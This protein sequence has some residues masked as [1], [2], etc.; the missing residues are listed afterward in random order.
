M[1]GSVRYE[2]LRDGSR[3]EPLYKREM[4]LGIS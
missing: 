1:N 2:V 3:T 4:F